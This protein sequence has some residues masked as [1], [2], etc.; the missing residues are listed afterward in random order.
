MG[1]AAGG[2]AA[3]PRLSGTRWVG[4]LDVFGFESTRQNSLE[5]LCI[6]FTNERLLQLCLHDAFVATRAAY[7][8]ERAN[9]SPSP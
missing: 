2:A 6:N 7:V 4:L 1:G 3:S 5:Q 9:P 8:E